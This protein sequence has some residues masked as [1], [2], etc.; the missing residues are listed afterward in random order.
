M[1]EQN[2]DPLE[3]YLYK[4]TGG[5]YDPRMVKLFIDCLKEW[6]PSTVG[7]SDSYYQGWNAYKAEVIENLKWNPNEK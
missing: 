1:T 7:S 3:L 2:K 5:K 4:K 6:L